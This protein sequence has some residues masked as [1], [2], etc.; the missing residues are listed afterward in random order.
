VNGKP[1]LNDLR[2][3]SDKV[4]TETCPVSLVKVRDSCTSGIE[5]WFFDSLTNN[6][7]IILSYAGWVSLLFEKEWDYVRGTDLL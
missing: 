1:A 3:R 6:M 7:V 4:A 5:L 2:R